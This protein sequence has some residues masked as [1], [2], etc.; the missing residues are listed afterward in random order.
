[1]AYWSNLFDRGTPLEENWIVR[2][3]SRDFSGLVEYEDQ[4]QEGAVRFDV[5]E[6][7]NFALMPMMLQGLKLVRSLRPDRIQEYCRQLTRE[8]LG[9]VVEMGYRLESDAFR[10]DHLF[11]IR[12]P[13]ALSLDRLKDALRERNVSVSVRGSAIRVAPN[14]YN[15]GRDIDA[16]VD[17]LRACV[18]ANRSSV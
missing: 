9:E 3:G 13:V 10:S 11:G 8:A 4:Y 15:D 18:T 14:V 16:L 17:A 5:G 1:M 12:A 6:R 2:Q 7:S